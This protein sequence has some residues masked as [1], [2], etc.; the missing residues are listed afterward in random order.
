[1][2]DL[3][4]ILY[5]L[6][7]FDSI[8]AHSNFK[9]Q[10]KIYKKSL[11]SHY[12]D[13]N[14]NYNEDLLKC[15]SNTINEI[16]LL[17]DNSLLDLAFE[18]IRALRANM[19]QKVLTKLPNFFL[20]HIKNLFQA[21]GKFDEK[22]LSD[23]HE[24][25]IILQLSIYCVLF[26]KI[27]CTLDQKMFKNLMEV[28]NKYCGITLIGGIVWNHVE[29]FKKRVPTLMKYCKVNQDFNKIQQ[30]FLKEKVQNL[31]RDTINYAVQVS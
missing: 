9:S 14:S 13:E 24:S 11:Q 26:Q 22:P 29:F 7:I 30:L 28:N 10:L 1:M 21:V 25:E 17:L 27:Y 8:I 2:E 4:N 6:L 19:K 5:N 20:S 16:E 18:N 31:G 3:G 15:L 23:F 12:I